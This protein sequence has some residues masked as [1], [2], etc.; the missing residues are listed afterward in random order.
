[1]AIAVNGNNLNPALQLNLPNEAGQVGERDINDVT[2]Q[3]N[4][5]RQKC[6]EKADSVSYYGL[7]KSLI[8]AAIAICAIIGYFHVC[9]GIVTTFSPVGLVLGLGSLALGLPILGAAIALGEK[10]SAARAYKNASKDITENLVR[11][12]NANNIELTPDNIPT[13]CKLYSLNI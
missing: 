7:P 13:I 3:V 2:D 4:A 11:Y 10:I 12:S 8:S 6:Q 9:L 1:M 5:L